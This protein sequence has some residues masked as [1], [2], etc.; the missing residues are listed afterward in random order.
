MRASASDSDT[1][2]WKQ[3]ETKQDRDEKSPVLLGS[4][5]IILHC[6]EQYKSAAAGGKNWPARLDWWRRCHCFLTIVPE[7]RGLLP[8]TV[9]YYWPAQL[10]AQLYNCARVIIKLRAY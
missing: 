6:C 4:A 1:P 7:M 10:F 9:A 2:T 8:C 3:W 5:L